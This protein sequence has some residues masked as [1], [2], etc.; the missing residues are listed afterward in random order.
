MVR[1]VSGLASQTYEEKLRELG[2]TTLE[3]RRHQ[4]DIHMTFKILK[5]VERVPVSEF[6]TMAAAGARQTRRNAGHLNLRA[7]HG[8]LDLRANFFTARVVDHW[9]TVPEEL[10]KIIKIGDFKNAYAQYRQTAV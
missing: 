4:A 1:Q 10:K 6:F 9:N 2:L 5:G 7:A 3:E 8:R